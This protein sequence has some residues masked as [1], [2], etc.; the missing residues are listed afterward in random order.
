MRH[1]ATHKKADKDKSN[2]NSQD[3]PSALGGFWPVSLH[4]SLEHKGEND[5]GGK[6]NHTH[7]QIHDGL[8]WCDL[9]L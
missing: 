7:H 5:E 1:V 4:V 9:Q 3:S 6:G 2:S 8:L